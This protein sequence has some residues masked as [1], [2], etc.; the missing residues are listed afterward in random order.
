MFDVQVEAGKKGGAISASASPEE[1]HVSIATSF[2]ATHDIALV[3]S[4]C[5]LL[6]VVTEQS[7][8][9]PHHCVSFPKIICQDR[10]TIVSCCMLQERGMKAGD[11]QR[12]QPK[13]SSS[14]D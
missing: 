10:V 9:H 12:G 2:L 11:A 13:G 6:P 14:S 3:T 1:R 8:P 7:C 5:K 4:R